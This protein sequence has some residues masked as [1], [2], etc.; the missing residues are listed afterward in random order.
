VTSEH[1]VVEAVH[2]E[3]IQ[4]TLRMAD[5]RLVGLNAPDAGADKLDYGYAITVHRSQGNTTASAHRFADG[6]GREL[7]YVSM[8][9]ATEHSTV[10]VVADDLEQARA[11]LVQGW[12][13]ERR[14][15]WV[16]DTGTPSTLAADIEE[17][18]EVSSRLREVIREARLRSERDAVARSIQP[19]VSQELNNT[20]DQL[21]RLRN[22]RERLERGSGGY[23]YTPEGR[24]GFI[25]R[26]V[27]YRLA[28]AEHRAADRHV[29]RSERRNARR[30]TERLTP[31]VE[32]ALQNWHEVAGPRHA[33]M[34]RDI[35]RLT[36]RVQALREQNDT[37]Q[38]WLERHPEALPR[39]ERLDRELAALRPAATVDRSVAVGIEPPSPALGLGIDGPDL[40]L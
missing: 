39:L 29:P 40:G 36:R 18:R 20:L 24:A 37:H 14:Q 17:A 34:T 12:S 2:P 26:G 4:M 33:A 3:G 30:E 25:L 1:G 11:D 7:G 38:S 22:D 32:A 21:A 10:Y 13:S 31:E 8:S 35:E 5:D 27:E 15:R 19:D 23:L 9:R 6:G 16:I 28:E